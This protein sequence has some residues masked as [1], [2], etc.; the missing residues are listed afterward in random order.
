MYNGS[1]KVV[2]N[3]LDK[4]DNTAYFEYGNIENTDIVD[5]HEKLNPLVYSNKSSMGDKLQIAKYHFQNQFEE[6]IPEHFVKDLW[7]RKLINFVRKFKM[8]YQNEDHILWSLFYQNGAIDTLE[9][10]NNP[11]WNIDIEK[12]KEFFMIGFTGTKTYPSVICKALNAYFGTDVYS[13]ERDTKGKRVRFRLP[14]SNKIVDKYVHTR[15]WNHFVP[16]IRQFLK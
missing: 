13:I 5:I 8:F 12:F 7:N 10:P 2:W 14:G 15:K 4:F 3:K 16:A 6:D 1:K 9:L 11:C